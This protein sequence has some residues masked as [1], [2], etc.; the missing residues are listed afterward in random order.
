MKDRIA[1]GRISVVVSE[2]TEYGHK[3]RTEYQESGT[4]VAF[5]I[6]KQASTMLTLL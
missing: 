5:T 4:Q 6:Q 1:R 3:G 2:E